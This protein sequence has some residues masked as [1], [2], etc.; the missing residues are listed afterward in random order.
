MRTRLFIAVSA[1]DRLVKKSEGLRIG[2][3]G[4]G[5]DRGERLASKNLLSPEHQEDIIRQELLNFKV[6]SRGGG[7][8]VT[9]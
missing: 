6:F 4:D 3:C 5:V 9:S 8:K 7:T 1:V 2:A